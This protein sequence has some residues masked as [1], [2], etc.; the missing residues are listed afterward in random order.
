MI[1]FFYKEFVVFDKMSDGFENG[2]NSTAFR[3]CVQNFVKDMIARVLAKG[4]VRSFEGSA[5]S[6]NYRSTAV[7][8]TLAHKENGREYSND[9]KSDVRRGLNVKTGR[10]FVDD[11]LSRTSKSLDNRLDSFGRKS[12]KID[13]DNGTGQTDGGPVD[14]FGDGPDKSESVSETIDAIDEKRQIVQLG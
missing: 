12:G 6:L 11:N 5:S 2:L 14:D 8:V 7:V 10:Y 13:S 4:N 3:Q 1:Y 9:N